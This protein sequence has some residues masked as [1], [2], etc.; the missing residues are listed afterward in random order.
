M[1]RR[2]LVCARCNGLV[3]DAGCPACRASLARMQAEGWDRVLVPQLLWLVGL[4]VLSLGVAAH[5]LR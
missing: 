1:P 3:R 4:L 2:D 5:V